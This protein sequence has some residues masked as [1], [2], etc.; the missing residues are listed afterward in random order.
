MARRRRSPAAKKP[1][2]KRVQV[3]GKSRKMT[4]QGGEIDGYWEFIATPVPKNIK[5]NMGRDNY[6]LS[7]NDSSVYEYDPE[8]EWM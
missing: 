6:F 4:F 3:E 1:K 8:R 2:R 7:T 5:M